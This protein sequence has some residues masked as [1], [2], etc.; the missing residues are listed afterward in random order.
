MWAYTLMAPA[1]FSQ[2]EVPEPHFDDAVADRVLLR[3]LAGGIC[4]SDL[5][6][7]RGLP[8]L[9]AAHAGAPGYPMHEIVGEVERS[10]APG[11]GLGERVVGWVSGMD[12][13]RERL[14]VAANDVQAYDPTLPPTTAVLLQPLACVLSALAPLRGAPP[15]TAAVLGLGPIG[16]LFAHALKAWG[17]SEIVGVDRVDRR[18]VASAFSIDECVHGDARS[19]AAALAPDDRPQVVVEA[20]GHQVG[21]LADAVDAV[22]VGGRIFYFGIPDDAVYPFPMHRFLR[23]DATLWAGY[24]RDKQVALAAARTHLADHPDLARSYVTDCFPVAQVQAAFD[25]AVVPALGRLKV[26]LDMA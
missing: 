21:T 5:P 9:Q 19:W 13:Q 22:A 26:V 4:G 8:P 1:T 23:K 3:A 2:Q 12:G 24:T 11:L 6:L 16:V 18:D 20:V 17:V 25:R 15:R 14:V 10:T 7:F